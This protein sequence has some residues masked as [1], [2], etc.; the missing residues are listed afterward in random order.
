MAQ[1]AVALDREA[2]S[3]AICLDL[4]KDPATLTCGHSYCMNCI[5]NHWDEEKEKQEYSCPQCRQ[6]FV[7]RPVLVKNTML[8]LLA[9]QLEKSGPPVDISSVVHTHVCCDVCTGSRLTAVKSCLQCLA[10]F[11]EKHLEP[12]YQ[13]AA[14]RKHQ[15]VV[16]SDKL[17]ENICPEHNEVKKMFCR[18][19]QQ[20]LC[21]VCCM[22]KH[23]GHRTVSAAAERAE[24]QAELEVRVDQILQRIQNKETDQD[25]L[26]Q[27]ALSLR[28]SADEA[29]RASEEIFTRLIHVMKERQAEVEQQIRTQQENEEARLKEHQQ[30]LQS[31][32][33]ELK[34]TQAQLNTLSLTPDHNR[35]IQDYPELSPAETALTVQRE[36]PG[37]FEHVTLALSTLSD[38]L[39]HTV[40]EGLDNISLAPTHVQQLPPQP[41]TPLT[42]AQPEKSLPQVK[43]ERLLLEAQPERPLPPN[44]PTTRK[45]FLKYAKEITLDL[46]TA[47]R[48]L[49][50]S[51]ENRRVTFDEDANLYPRNPNRFN[52]YYQVLSKQRLTGRCYWEVKWSTSATKWSDC[53]ITIA[54]SYNNIKRKDKSEECKFGFNENSWALYCNKDEDY[55][56]YFNEDETEVCGPFSSRIGVYLDHSAG[57]LSFY[58]VTTSMNLLYRVQTSFTQPLHAGVRFDAKDNG[59]TAYFPKLN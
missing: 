16:P 57:V 5:H 4:L 45:G 19:D 39:Q 11:C 48:Q 8:A 50:L 32:I 22:D 30:L 24:K 23:A 55:T 52:Y 44:E 42:Q 49:S 38:L 40:K 47:H 13:S 35:F 25:R 41:E 18:S 36:P 20:L 54:V 31:E 12:H 10:S 9:E 51:D 14:L 26:H 15:L 28:C 29:V 33:S 2:F 7:S 58:S 21:V 59:A 53:A 6:S 37:S 46:N 27:E 1:S 34:K 17:Q 3:C 56:F 43:L